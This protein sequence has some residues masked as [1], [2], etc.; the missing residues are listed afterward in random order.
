MQEVSEPVTTFLHLT[1][2]WLNLY[3]LLNSEQICSRLLRDLYNRKG[4]K[5]MKLHG[6]EVTYKDKYVFL[7]Y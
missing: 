3:A 1:R 7:V 2:V 6:W 4:I 5:E